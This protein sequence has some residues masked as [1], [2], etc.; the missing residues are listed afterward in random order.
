VISSAA[1]SVATRRSRPCSRRYT[2]TWRNR[3]SAIPYLVHRIVVESTLVAL[4]DSRAI[5]NRKDDEDVW[6]RQPP[7]K[8]SAA[9]N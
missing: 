1:S 7:M 5:F 6:P 4:I 2:S 9:K 8:G 3:Q